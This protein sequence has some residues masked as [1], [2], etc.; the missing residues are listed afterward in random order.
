MKTPNLLEE[1]HLRYYQFTGVYLAILFVGL[2]PFLNYSGQGNE[3]WFQRSGALLVVAGVMLEITFVN[4][5][6]KWG[7]LTKKEKK[8]FMREY[9]KDISAINERAKHHVTIPPSF[10]TEAPPVSLPEKEVLTIASVTGVNTKSIHA[11]VIF[12][13]LIWGYGDL[14]YLLV[15]KLLVKLIV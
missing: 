14:V 8:K 13:T 3:I 6:R 2:M 12:G 9:R 1:I 11:S 7:S 10:S 4:H 15:A 5:L